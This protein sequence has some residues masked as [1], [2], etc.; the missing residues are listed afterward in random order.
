[1]YLTL[2]DDAV[3]FAEVPWEI[4]YTLFVHGCKLGC[5]GCSWEGLEKPTYNMSLDEFNKKLNNYKNKATCVVFLGGEWYEDFPLFLRAA[6]DSGFKTCLYTGQSCVSD[7]LLKGLDY[8][9]TGR[10]MGKPLTDK[11]TNQQFWIISNGKIVEEKKF[12]EL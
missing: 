2:Y 7:E 1:M 9:K 6:R 8:L 5:K 12:Y 4:N 3:T 11:D 10:W